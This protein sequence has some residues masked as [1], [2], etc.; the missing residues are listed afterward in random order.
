MDKQR[1]GDL[2]N[3]NPLKP[4]AALTISDTTPHVSNSIDL[5]RYDRVSFQLITTGTLDGAW[6]VEISNNVVNSGSGAYGQVAATGT[7]TDITSGFSPAIASVDHTN[8]ATQSQ[9]AQA[10]IRIRAIRVT[11]TGTAGT[12][13]VSVYI[14]ATEI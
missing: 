14:N 11:F 7:W 2:D 5:R 3:E 10:D 13:A 6:K 8:A 9:Y 4:F 1:Y 12:G